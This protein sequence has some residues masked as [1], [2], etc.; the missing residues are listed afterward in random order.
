MGIDLKTT[1]KFIGI[2]SGIWIDEW[3]QAVDTNGAAI[4]FS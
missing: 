4:Q 2:I 1:K 3:S